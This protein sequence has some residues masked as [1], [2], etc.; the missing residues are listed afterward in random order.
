MGSTTT[1]SSAGFQARLARSERLH[2]AFVS[3]VLLVLLTVFCWRRESHGLVMSTDAV[4]FPMV[5]V[6]IGGIAF[7][8]FVF[9][10]NRHSQR[11]GAVGRD[12]LMRWTLLIDLF[13]PV[14]LLLILQDHSPRGQYAALSAPSLL[15]MPI[16][17]L[18]SVLRL[19]PW[20][21]LGIG[22]AAALS[23]AG[24]VA[25]AF[26]LTS[27]A[28]EHAPL[29]Y[30][31]AIL[32]ALTG[33][34]AAGV[35]WLARDYVLEAAKEAT[36]AEQASRDKALVERELQVAHEIQ[37]GLL[38]TEPPIL[39]SFDIAGMCRP[40]AR[41]GG[42]YFD[43]QPL[44]DGRLVVVI[45]DVS[46]HGVGPALVTAVCRAYARAT[47][48]RSP[49]AGELLEVLNRHICEDVKGLR[50][51]TM[52]VLVLDTKGGVEMLSAGH[53][54]TFLYRAGEGRVETFGGD[55]LPLGI[56]QSATYGPLRR[57]QMAPGDVMLLSTD[58][59]Y[60][61]SRTSDD[62]LFGDERMKDFLIA[63]ASKTAD[64]L[65]S[66]LDR[67]VL[68]FAVGAPQE[69]DMTAVAIRRVQ[70]AM[71]ASMPSSRLRP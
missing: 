49:D 65:L 34:A 26:H 7:Q 35:S 33:L 30:S 45:A 39:P 43:W 57:V 21:S 32:L 48:P 11:N 25:R 8:G 67:T 68:D 17:I 6:L 47:A 31:Y 51:I 52:Y 36:A 22:L 41:A 55:G 53:G 12:G 56:V 10:W 60:E 38:P 61:Y 46:G 20:L 18:L 62:E 15:L 54:P 69:D 24:L 3:L 42:D 13:V 59:F 63:N 5:Y 2:Q 64:E 23:H 19:R 1:F 14:A 28:Q 40:A 37:M 71:G 58:G 27:I 29:L 16:V 4:F 44:P 9:L 70:G 50:F 66:A